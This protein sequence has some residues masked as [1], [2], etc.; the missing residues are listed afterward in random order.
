MIDENKLIEKLRKLKENVYCT[1]VYCTSVDS[2][3]TGYCIAIDKAIELAVQADRIEN[4][5]LVE[6]SIPKS[7]ELYQN[8]PG[9]IYNVICPNCGEVLFMLTGLDYEFG[10]EDSYCPYCGQALK[11]WSEENE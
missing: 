5:K 1:S 11:R 9:T 2:F 8:E 6:K 10:K 7:V 3:A 4:D